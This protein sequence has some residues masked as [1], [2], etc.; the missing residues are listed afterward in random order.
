M[1]AAWRKSYKSGVPNTGLFWLC[2]SLTPS[3]LMLYWML[4]HQPRQNFWW[5]ATLFG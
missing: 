3:H 2:W 5:S 1:T 4:Y